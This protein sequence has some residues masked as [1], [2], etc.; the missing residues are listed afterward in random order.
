[1]TL[2]NKHIAMLDRQA[3]RELLAGLRAS[4][5]CQLDSQA[6]SEQEE[7][8]TQIQDSYSTRRKGTILDRIPKTSEEAKNRILADAMAA[9][10]AMVDEIPDFAIE[11]R[12]RREGTRTL[13]RSLAN[14]FM[15]LADEICNLLEIGVTHI[16]AHLALRAPALLDLLISVADSPELLP[17][18][19]IGPY[20]LRHL[21]TREYIEEE[22]QEQ[23][24][25]Y[26]DNL[27]S[28]QLG[29]VKLM[30]K[31]HSV[32]L[33]TIGDLGP[34]RLAERGAPH[35]AAER[36]AF[37]K[38]AGSWD[39]ELGTK[40]LSPRDS[41]LSGKDL[42]FYNRNYKP[43]RKFL[44]FCEAAFSHAIEVYR[45]NYKIDSAVRAAIGH[46]QRKLY[47]KKIPTS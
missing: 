34:V 17:T 9:S 8:R 12:Y 15:G 19:Q 18:D 16:E 30:L 3:V 13:L 32:C 1:M 23:I 22:E 5:R 44:R 31:F 28:W 20:F 10:M 40:L 39:R 38:C 24:A 33:F 26:G 4:Y 46:Q 25:S 29:L 47:V 21:H 37:A 41:T 43:Y 36:N 27:A 35:N 7:L 6:L 42:S 2:R 14:G 45:D 11:S